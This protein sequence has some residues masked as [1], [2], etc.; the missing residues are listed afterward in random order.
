MVAGKVGRAVWGLVDVAPGDIAVGTAAR[1]VPTAFRRLSVASFQYH[2]A[3]APTRA[4]LLTYKGYGIKDPALLPTQTSRSILAVE[5]VS[6]FRH[7]IDVVYWRCVRRP[8]I[9]PVGVIICVAVDTEAASVEH[10][11][12][13][14]AGLVVRDRT[15]GW[16][17]DGRSCNVS[18]DPSGLSGGGLEHLTSHDGEQH[19]NEKRECLHDDENC[20]RSIVDGTGRCGQALEESVEIGNV[21][22]RYRRLCAKGDGM[23]WRR[24][25]Q[26]RGLAKLSKWD[27]KPLAV[28]FPRLSQA[29]W[30]Q[31]WS[32]SD[33]GVL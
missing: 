23:E 6:I 21:F 24:V 19:G 5:S 13:H 25:A 11:G 29:V 10:V 4:G 33:D 20:G 18:S 22:L 9:V 8:I 30:I 15:G 32:T 27:G 12:A 1:K 2:G 16:N 31:T 28:E 17:G 7:R 14:G 26:T 3:S